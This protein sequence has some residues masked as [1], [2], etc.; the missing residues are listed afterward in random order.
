MAAWA[1]EVDQELALNVVRRV[2][3]VESAHLRVAVA[4]ETDQVAAQEPVL[5]VARR[6]T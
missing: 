4:E 1:V 2:I 3:S 5:S 6:V